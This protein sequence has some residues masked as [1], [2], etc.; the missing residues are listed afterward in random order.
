M[1]TTPKIPSLFGV[2]TVLIIPQFS[3]TALL[4]TYIPFVFFP[5]NSITPVLLFIALEPLPE[6][7]IPIPSSSATLIVPLFV[8]VPLDVAIPIPYSGTGVAVK[9]LPLTEITALFVAFPPLIAY[10]A[11]L[12]VPLPKSIFALFTTVP[13]E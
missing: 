4:S 2:G 1:A 3:P 6:A 10:I 11:T 5:L 8:I 9:L 7:N 12:P 13:G